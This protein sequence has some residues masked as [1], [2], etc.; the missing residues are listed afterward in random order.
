MFILQTMIESPPPNPLEV[1]W[2]SLPWM[3]FDKFYSTWHEFPPTLD[4]WWASQPMRKQL[5]SLMSLLHQWVHFPGKSNEHLSM[6]GSPL[7]KFTDASSPTACTAGI[8]PAG[9]FQVSLSLI[10]L[11][12]KLTFTFVSSPSCPLPFPTY[13]LLFSPISLS[14]LS[15]HILS[16]SFS[17]PITTSSPFIPL[18]GAGVRCGAL[19]ML[20]MHFV[21]KLHPQLHYFTLSSTSRPCGMTGNSLFSGQSLL[22]VEWGERDGSLVKSICCP[23]VKTGVLFSEATLGIHTHKHF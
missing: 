19:L 7:D 21:T 1:L 16:L 15:L 10:S 5:V 2:P 4:E 14:F 20:N 17:L 3:G 13:H 9:S 11:G 12:L 18:S 8:F 22:D 6:Q 23:K